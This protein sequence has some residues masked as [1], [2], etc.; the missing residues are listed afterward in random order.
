M[1]ET[2]LR[3][4]C[5]TVVE[6]GKADEAIRIDMLMDGNMADEDDLGRLDGL[7]Y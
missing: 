3:Q 5:D 4:R 7:L 6:N 2:T 1:R